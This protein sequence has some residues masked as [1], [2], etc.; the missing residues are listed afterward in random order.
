MTTEQSGFSPPTEFY[1]RGLVGK[2]A[3][4]PALGVGSFLTIEFGGSRRNSVGSLVGEYHLWVYSAAWTIFREAHVLA[5]SADEPTS[6]ASA[7]S[8]PEGLTVVGIKYDP[9]RFDLEIQFDQS[10]RLDMVSGQDDD[11]EH[12]LLYLPDGWVVTAG[13]G[14]SIVR[15]R[16][17]SE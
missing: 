7:V 4:G 5:T 11:M 9:G 17:G 6:M 8:A 15:E 12:W 3:W 2:A 16:A 10:I 14:D 13:P 1:L